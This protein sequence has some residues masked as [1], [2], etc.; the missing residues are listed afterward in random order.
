MNKTKKILPE[1]RF[2]EFKNDGEWIE[3]KLGL[4]SNITIGEFV[5]KTKQNPN[6][7]YPVYN[8]GISYTGF[9]DE[10]NNEANKIVI[11]AR[12]ANAGFV[13]LIKEKYWAGNSCYSVEILNEN[14][15]DLEFLF[16]YIKHNQR[17]FTDNQQAANIPS[18]SKSDVEK[19]QVYYPENISEQ[20]KIA[21]CLSS[22]DE[23]ISAHSQKLELLKAH[24]KGLMQNLFP[25]EGKK[26][27]N[28]RFPEF[29]DSGEWE[30]ETLGKVYDFKSTNSLSREYLSYEK[31]IVKNIHYGD[32][33][34]TF[35]TLFDITKE[36]VP[37]IKYCVPVKIKKDNYC[38]EG[39]II[40]ADA[41]E[42]IDDIGKSIE[43]INLN[44]E[45]LVS[46]LHTLLARQ[47]KQK[48]AIGFGGY[49]F[50]SDWFRKQIQREAQGAKVLGISATRISRIRI[51]FPQNI[52][53]QQKI[54]S[55]LS[56]LDELITAQSKKIEQLKQHKKGLMQGLFPKLKN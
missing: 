22:L 26:V 18:I 40:F 54:A 3:K 43:I 48:L 9:Y 1:L 11:S 49:L 8:G 10:Y 42:D 39:D 5:I 52:I 36:K 34:T 25:Q 51:L 47:R 12:G 29:K 6:S 37:F 28:Y 30:E 15:T 35:N 7:L 19:F 14:K 31:G 4:L 27:P 20:Q 17:I 21:A 45:K 2:P 38:I 50:K 33:H 56:S 16:Y 46:G 23:L 32:I 44:N 53:E 55:C 41:S 13:N 24:K